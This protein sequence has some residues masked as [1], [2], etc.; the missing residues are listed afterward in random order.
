MVCQSHGLSVYE[1]VSGSSL[2]VCRSDLLFSTFSVVLVSH[3]V[4]LTFRNPLLICL[5]VSIYLSSGPKKKGDLKKKE[6]INHQ[7]GCWRVGL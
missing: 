5:S 4:D 1:S 7:R 2:S 6:A 3:S